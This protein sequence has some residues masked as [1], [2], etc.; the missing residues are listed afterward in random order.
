MAVPF[1]LFFN[2]S[3]LKQSSNYKSGKVFEVQIVF[4][5]ICPDFQTWRKMGN[6]LKIHISFTYY[7]A[8]PPF[9]S[10]RAPDPVE[11]LSAGLVPVAASGLTCC[12]PV[13]ASLSRLA[14]YSLFYKWN[15]TF[16]PD[17]FGLVIGPVHS[18]QFG[19][20]LWEVWWILALS[21]RK[22]GLS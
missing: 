19:S 15:Y 18:S 1:F 11:P 16:E 10:S 7:L 20:D 5:I 17:T 3:C 13:L 6:F 14:R 8:S 22:H 12:A 2:L 4:I 21:L 9:S